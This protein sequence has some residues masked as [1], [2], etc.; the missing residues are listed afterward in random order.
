MEFIRTD[1]EGLFVIK[2]KVFGDERG[3]FFESFREDL[4]TK[5][6]GNVTF[7]QDNE[8]KSSYGVLRGLHYQLPPYAQSKLIR[9]VAGEILDVVVDIRKESDTFGKIFA[10]T[11]SG[12][13]K[14][15]LFVPKGFAHGFVVLSE[16]AIV[17]YKVDAYYSPQHERGIDALDPALAIDWIVPYRQIIRSEKDSRLPV[18]K[19]A[20][21]L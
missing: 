2:P 3:Y 14:N 7:V 20:E 18:L 13:N 15:Q 12:D 4:F 6:I 9:V 11:L 16:S 21:L 5:H 1:F 17:N 19:E 8:S 10:T